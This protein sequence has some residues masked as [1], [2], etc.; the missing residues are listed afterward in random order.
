MTQPAL[1]ADEMLTW[2]EKTS[3]RFR[4]LLAKHPEAL[5][6]SCD[7][8]KVSTLGGL[9]Q[10]IVAV[11]LRYAER[12]AG[13]PET[14][15]DQVPF[16]TVEEIFETHD[17]AIALFREALAT[18]GINWDEELEFVTRS[19]GKMIATRK[20]VF[21]HA[22]SHSIRHYAQLTTLLRQH[23]ITMPLPQDYLMV[24]ARIA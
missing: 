17:R 23:G 21:F 11:E 20:A 24:A 14:Q 6:F 4:D 16:A 9:M 13:Q 8:A 12:L 22:L 7:I 15:Y 19:L 3:T 10:H 18:S 5:Q 2:N 1:T